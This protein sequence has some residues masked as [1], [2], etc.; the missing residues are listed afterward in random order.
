[1]GPTLFDTAFLG[2]SPQDALDFIINILQSSTNDSI[3][4]H[5]VD[6]TI[7]L[8]NEGARRLYGYAAEEPVG[9]TSAKSCLLEQGARPS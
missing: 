6:G 5:D 9:Q 1:V 4:G 8:W 3:T 7:R 2:T